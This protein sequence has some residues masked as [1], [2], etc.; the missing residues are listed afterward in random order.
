MS[1]RVGT[2]GGRQVEYGASVEE[3]V[4]PVASGGDGARYVCISYVAT[5]G[6][7]R[8]VV[9]AFNG[10]PGSSSVWLHLGIGPRR[11]A[12]GDDLEP[13]M[14]PPYELVDNPD[15]VLDE[16]DLVFVDPP[17]TGYSRVL[18]E[19]QEKEFYGVERDAIATIRF[20]GRWARRHGRENSPKY[21][22]GESYGAAR[23][24]TIARMSAGGPTMTGGLE[25][26]TLNGVVLLGPSLSMAS[27]QTA[28]DYATALPSLAAA[29]WYHDRVAARSS[30]LADHIDVAREFAAGEYLAA[31]FAGNR[32]DRSRRSMVA[33]QLHELIG[34]PLDVLEEHQLRVTP[35]SYAKLLL[36]DQ[37]EHLGLC[38]ARYRLSADGA[39]EDPVG[40]DPAMGQYTPAFAGAIT[41]YLRDELGADED[42]DYRAIEF[43]RVN[44]RWDYGDEPGKNYAMDLAI[45]MRRN[46]DFR[47]LIGVGSYDLVTTLGATE[48]ALSQV[49][50]D[51]H[52]T[53]V[54]TYESGHMPYLGTTP[55]SDLANDLRTFVRST[56]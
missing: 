45:A 25:A 52:R 32:L 39:G 11:V 21:L 36:A 19:E 24:A 1:S 55:R 4:V 12:S 6:E 43:A 33:K 31:L 26:L 17:G 22:L 20:I 34:L 5:A 49:P 7:D 28:I 30:K 29:A 50:L 10:G 14:V 54:H 51:Q 18:S 2:F 42:A 35:P 53:F 56:T 46:R 44:Q 15:C 9:F 23:A 13:R 37:D 16:A 27:G 48:H 40:D 8:P 3:I 41:R 38:D 47:V